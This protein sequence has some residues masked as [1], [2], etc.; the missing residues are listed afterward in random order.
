MYTALRIVLL[1]ASVFAVSAFALVIGLVPLAWAVL[2]GL[3]LWKLGSKVRRSIAHGSARWAELADIEHMLEGDGLIL[4]RMSGRSSK[5]RAIKAL[6]DPRLAPRTACE[7][8]LEGFRASRA[9]PVVRLTNSVHTLVCAPTGSGKG[10]SLMV[11]YLLTCRDSMVVVDFKSELAS[12]T[13][14]A[15][16]AMGHRVILLDPYH[17]GTREPD[18]FNPIEF[19]D[20]DSPT[21]IDDCRD[22]AESL[23]IRTGE[24]KEPHWN[25]S[26]EVWIAAMIALVVVIAERQD[27]SLQ[28]VRTLLTD[29]DRMQA[30]IDLMRQSEAMDGMLARLGHQLTHF[31]DKE[32]ASTLTSVNRHLRFLDSTAI[33]ES[34]RRSTFDPADLL[35]GKTT[36][37]LILPPDRA[38]AQSPLLRMWIGSL[39][40]AVVKGGL[41]NSTGTN[42]VHFVLDEAS[43]LGHMDAIDNAVDQLRGYGVRLLFLFQS[44]GQLKKCFPDGQ[45]QTLLSNCTQ[46]F[47]GVSDQQTAEYVSARLGETTITTESGGTSRSTSTQRSAQGESATVS[48]STNHNWSYMGRKL[49]TAAEVTALPERVAI[50]FTPGVPPIATRLIRYYERDFKNIQGPSP[51]RTALHAIFLSIVVIVLAVMVAAAVLNPFAH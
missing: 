26:A 40:R 16:R 32:L 41:Q 31:K 9:N 13:A 24:E 27:R 42:K 49:L 37:H 47:F 34:T 23:V 36:V 18:T 3:I 8:F 28:S 38:R 20:R 35:K 1:L 10:V 15:R 51:V 14:R 44:L 43:S 12:L 5:L 29:P 50:T 46:V 21:A 48:N 19:I 25:D 6:V 33:A 45:E 7:R 4:G 30:A 39:L 17:T 11:P 22:L 2:I